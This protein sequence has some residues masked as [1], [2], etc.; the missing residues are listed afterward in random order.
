M[1]VAVEAKGQ[2]ERLSRKEQQP[3]LAGAQLQQQLLLELLRD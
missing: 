3:S 1:R 2:P